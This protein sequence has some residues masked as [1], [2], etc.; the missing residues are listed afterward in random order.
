[1]PF[2]AFFEFTPLAPVTVM[3]PIV[4]ALYVT[5]TEIAKPLLYSTP[6]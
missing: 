4:P 3:L 1:L 5:A 6:F 2:A